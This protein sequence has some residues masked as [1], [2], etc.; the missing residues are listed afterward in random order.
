MGKGSSPV[1]HLH[2]GDNFQRGQALDIPHHIQR[3]LSV[4]ENLAA[5]SPFHAATHWKQKVGHTAV[6]SH[7]G[8]LNTWSLV[9]L[10]N[11]SPAF[12]GPG[13]TAQVQSLVFVMRGP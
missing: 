12:T 8:F 9:W 4:N 5:V 11:D 6:K 13:H 7:T 3:G 1:P 2:G 10:F